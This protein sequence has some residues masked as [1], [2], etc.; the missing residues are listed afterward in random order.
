LLTLH[1][2]MFYFIIIITENVGVGKGSCSVTFEISRYDIMA[3][4]SGCRE[5]L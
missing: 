5:I 4:F 1:F 3:K 2:I